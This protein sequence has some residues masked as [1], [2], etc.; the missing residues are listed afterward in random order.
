MQSFRLPSHLEETHFKPAIK[1]LDPGKSLEYQTYVGTLND[2]FDDLINEP[3]MVET[4]A[5]RNTR[6]FWLVPRV[7][8]S[9]LDFK[10]S[11]NSSAV[12]PTIV[13]EAADF[14]LETYSLGVDPSRTTT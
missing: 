12:S 3:P 7:L 9:V 13:Q 2:V 1:P 6:L 8:R 14:L 10:I 11:S 5:L 4:T